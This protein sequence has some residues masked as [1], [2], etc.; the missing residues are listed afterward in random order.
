MNDQKFP[1]PQLH[2]DGATPVAKRGLGGLIRDHFSNGRLF[3][4]VGHHGGLTN[5]SYWGDQHLGAGGFFQ[6]ALETGWHKN[7]R[8]YVAID[9]KNYYPELNDTRLMPFGFT[10]HCVEAGVKMDYDLLL[11]PDTL[12]QRVKFA[13]NPGRRTLRIGMIH[14][15]DI[16]AVGGSNRTWQPF[17][18]EKKFNAFVTSCR[19]INPPPPVRSASE[20]SLAQ[21]D[22]GP[23]LHDSPDVTTWIA[24]GCDV[25]FTVRGSYHARSKQYIRSA[26]FKKKEAAFYL[27]FAR[28]REELE[29]RLAMLK[30]SVHRECHELLRGYETRLRERP[31]I[32]VGDPVLNSAFGQFPE[33]IHHMKVPDMPGAAKATLA[34]YWVWGWDGMMPMLPSPLANE[35]EYDIDSFRFFHR[36]IDKRFGIPHQFSTG[37]ELKL[38]GPF[39]SQCQYIASLYHYV[40][41]TGNLKI[42]REVFSTCQFILEKCRRDVVGYTALARLSRGDG[43]ERPRH[44]LDE[45]LAALPGAALD[46]ISRHGAGREGGRAR[47]PRVGAQ[48]P[49]ELREV[50]LRRG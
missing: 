35:R 47:L 41:I 2:F 16:N 29:K 9:E 20:E 8:F 10:S 46:G 5:V 19:D 34:G 50:S 42:A 48:D 25:P 30:R 44:Q 6:G 45:Q 3:C 31:Q 15:E 28:S 23:E 33:M 32:D 17:V 11:L 1:L 7:F 18:F 37:F 39:P 12:V 26:F 38:K 22:R 24:L 4:T 21:V 14:Q 13:G 27:V 36:T 43:G 49:R 40:A